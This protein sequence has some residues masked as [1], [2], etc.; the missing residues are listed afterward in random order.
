MNVV[1]HPIVYA[2]LLGFQYFLVV[3]VFAFAMGAFR[4]LVLAPRL[5]P[6]AAVLLE[7]PIIIA[8]SWFGIRW[9]LRKRSFTF[10][11]RAVVGATAFSLTLASE[12]ALA[13]PLRGENVMEWAATLTTPLGLVGLAGQIVF[14]MMPI[15]VGLNS[16]ANVT[17]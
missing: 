11:Q 12:A 9:L 13:V 6:M 8:I 14:A 5:G 2:T 1:K 17:K 15:V 7:V 16:G 10:G 4:G 3:F